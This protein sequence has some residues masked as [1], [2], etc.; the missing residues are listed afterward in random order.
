MSEPLPLRAAVIGSVAAITAIGACT[1]SGA[2]GSSSGGGSIGGAG[3][4]ADYAPHKGP[5]HAQAEPRPAASATAAASSGGA[6]SDDSTLSGPYTAVALGGSKIRTVQMS[7]QVRRGASVADQANAA[8]ALV[9]GAGGEVDAD[10]RSSGRYAQATL[11][12][13]VPPEQLSP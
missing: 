12:L 11:V 1:Q 3:G 7:V 2:G 8:E 4:A 5:G 9:A 13:K 6:P 10:D